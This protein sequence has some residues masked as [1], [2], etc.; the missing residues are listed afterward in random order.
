MKKTASPRTAFL[1][2]FRK[3]DVLAYVEQ[4]SV[5]YQNEIAALKKQMADAKAERDR[6]VA[7]CKAAKEISS[8]T[9][10]LRNGLR[11]SYDEITDAKTAL[12]A[13]RSEIESL[14]CALESE[15]NV[16]AETCEALTAERAGLM[17]AKAESER[18]AEKVSELESDA[19]AKAAEL[20]RN[21]AAL[22]AARA[23]AATL[24]ETAEQLESAATV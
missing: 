16:L 11:I 4:I 6:A 14:R 13:A 17:A 7:E 21:A 8:E 19:A 20:D 24:R 23:F 2:G 12:E 1:G 10:R 5:G 3:D 18:L 22:S 9:E 15:R